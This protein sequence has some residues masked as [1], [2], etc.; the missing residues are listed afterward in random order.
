MS[1]LKIP[2]F[3]LILERLQAKHLDNHFIGAIATP[4]CDITLERVRIITFATTTL[5]RQFAIFIQVRLN[6]GAKTCLLSV[7]IYFPL[8]MRDKVLK[9][10]LELH[11]ISIRRLPRYRSVP[12]CCIGTPNSR[13]DGIKYSRELR[14]GAYIIIS[15]K[16]WL[17]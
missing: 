17:K 6:V 13:G 12:S 16:K 7:M 14:S 11:T 1:P 3:R 15:R 2:A 5:N 4:P 10:A 9:Q 8:K